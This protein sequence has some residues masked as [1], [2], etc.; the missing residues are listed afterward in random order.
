[1]MILL[2]YLGTKVKEIRNVELKFLC[3]KKLFKGWQQRQ[4]RS[5]K[6]S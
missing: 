2:I 1:M 3:F 5:R 6:G 4:E